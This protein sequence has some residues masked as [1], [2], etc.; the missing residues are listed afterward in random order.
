MALVGKVV[1]LTGQA[2]LVD[3]TG[4]QRP[5][6][7]GD[8]LQPG[9]TIVAPKGVMVELELA[10]GSHVQIAS[11]QTVT[12][13]QELSDAILY[14]QIDPS[15]NAVTQES[16]QTV[17][18]AI[19]SGDN[20]DDIIQALASAREN[21]SIIEHD[22]HTFVDLLRIDDVLNQ[23]DYNY[24]VA[25][26]QYLDSDPLQ[27]DRGV[28][29]DGINSTIELPRID[30]DLGRFD[31]AFKGQR[32][33]FESRR[34]FEVGE[35][36]DNAYGGNGGGGSPSVPTVT[37]ISAPSA[38][39]GLALVYSVTLSG[40][41]STSNTLPFSLG[42]GTAAVS[43]YGTPV[44]SNG[45][46]LNAGVLTIPPGVTSF[47]VTVPASTDSI[48]EG[49]ETL[50]LT[51]GGI[52]ATG[53]IVDAGAVPVISAVSAASQTEGASLVHT[54]TLS[55]ASSS[56]T[57]F[58]FTLGGGTSTA[59]GADFNGPPVF[60]NG[61]TLV[62]AN[63]NIPA[64]VSS[65]TISVP[66]RQ[67][68]IDEGASETYNVSVGGVIAVGTIVDNDAAPIISAISA[69]SQTEG[70]SL[71]HTVTLSNASSSP[72][73]FAF[74]I[75]GG[76]TNASSCQGQAPSQSRRRPDAASRAG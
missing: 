21:N 17:I 60:S 26:E 3:A 65:F 47:T 67:D 62:G 56:P 6:V 11:Q 63:L 39:E 37:A 75:S 44:F 33:T 25:S 70:A 59:T 32:E 4:A 13:S 74:S 64:G 72:T 19:D 18:E 41:S 15:N 58:A 51:V 49:N 16:I 76:S 68:T 40:A 5:L 57:S 8:S 55:F 69:A 30:E 66:T 10:N 54:V 7:L 24:D 50:P 36:D 22:G 45:V 46:T 48:V 71:V 73:S 43:D 14:D 35:R 34:N 31:F 12:F 27:Q 53:I 38:Q 20:I 9:D 2:I 52:S 1:L 28:Q 61:V 42:G 23:F 29:A